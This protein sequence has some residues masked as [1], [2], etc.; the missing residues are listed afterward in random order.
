MGNLYRERDI[1]QR[2]EHLKN[3]VVEEYHENIPQPV[4]WLSAS[5]ASVL[6]ASVNTLQKLS[7]TI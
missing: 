3:D 7:T 6:F 4:F 1:P 2:T 5:P